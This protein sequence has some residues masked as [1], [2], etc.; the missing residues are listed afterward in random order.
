MKPKRLCTAALAVSVSIVLVAAAVASDDDSEP[1]YVI[2]NGKRVPTVIIP[3][4]TAQ[5]AVLEVVELNPRAAA[6]DERSD[7]LGRLPEDDEFEG[8]EQT[9][10]DLR[11]YVVGQY[12]GYPVSVP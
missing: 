11:R 7:R 10:D 2:H 4:G 8:D 9:Y 6:E 12:A 5:R 1:L 3:P